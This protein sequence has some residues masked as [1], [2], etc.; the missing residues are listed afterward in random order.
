MSTKNKKLFTE[1][2]PVTTEQWESLIKKD[3]KGKD[4]EETLVQKTIE[5]IKIK[6]YYR[7][8]DIKN[9]S[10]K[11]TP[12]GQ[13]PYVR[14][15]KTNGN[16]WEIRQDIKVEDVKKANK[17]ALDALMKGA[18]SLGFIVNDISLNEKPMK[19]LLRDIL[20][21]YVPV[22][23]IAGNQSPE[24]LNS[25][26][27]E[28]KDRK[29]PPNQIKGSVDFDPV[30]E[31]TINGN[32]K[33]SR[34][35]AFEKAAHLVQELNKELPLFQVINI[36]GQYIHNAGASI[37]QE[38]GMSLAQANEYLAQLREK[39]LKT[40][41]I[42]ARIRFTFATGSNYLM[43]IAKIRVARMLWA[44][45]VEQY[46]PEHSCS[47]ATFIHCTTSQWNTTVY[48][49]YINMLR[50]TTETMSAAIGGAD[51]I[52]VIPFDYPYKTPGEFSERMAR[53]TQ[54]VIGEEA[55]LNKVADPSGG[56]YH[57]EKLTDSIAQGAW[58]IFKIIES[59]GGFI[60]SLENGYI[61][62][63]IEKT[64]ALK[65]EAILSGKTV[66]LGTNKHPDKNERMAGKIQKAKAIHRVTDK[67]EYLVK[68]LKQYRAAEK[69]EQE[70]LAK[71]K[72]ET[73]QRLKLS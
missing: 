47:M 25:L 35:T 64:A 30:G 16:S 2:P 8:E 45:I 34:A 72:E 69:P 12:P 44:K 40:D 39:G 42:T 31:L 13:Y 3:L 60:A 66:L 61:Q 5:G 14:G 41:D 46:Q 6:P 10:Y 33:E 18:T 38:L 63:E 17:K 23:F 28:V 43:E 58:E 1:F 59:K 15:N 73:E 24:V 9:L 68:P 65:E 19:I 11:N 52:S 48:D 49:S 55:Y 56:S 27:K 22:N 4:Y 36:N 62:S 57:I 7:E 51:S 67:K 29:L 50:A 20:I 26:I 21:E 70:R 32:W 53:N 54:I 37:V 71:E